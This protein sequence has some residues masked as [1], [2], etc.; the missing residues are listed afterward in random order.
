MRGV[1][2]WGLASSSTAPVL[3]VGGWTLAARLQPRHFDPVSSSI[4]ALAAA[5]ATDRRVLT[6]ALLGVGIR[7]VLTGLCPVPSTQE[8]PARASRIS[9]ASGIRSPAASRMLMPPDCP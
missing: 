2:W 3:I 6:L 5:G 7:H 4:S 9:S 8:V 1:P